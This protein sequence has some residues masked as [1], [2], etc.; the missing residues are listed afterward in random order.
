[1]N[2]KRLIGSLALLLSAAV[3]P[4]AA[5]AQDGA[6]KTLVVG[7]WGGDIERLLKQNAA[8]PLEADTGAKVEFLLG[9]SGDR[10]SKI[11][12]ERSNPTMDVAFVNIYEAPQ[13][14]KDGLVE[15]PDPDS[16]MFKDVWDG[17]NKGCYAMSLV[18]LGIAYNKEAFATPP[19][20]ADLWKP[21]YKGKIA[22]ATYPGSEGDG[23]L[24]V[25]ARLAGKDEH[26]ADAAFKKLAELGPPA[27]TYT[28]LDEVFAQM[29][30]GEV[31]AAPMISGYVLA[32]LKQWKNIGFSFPKSPGPVLVRDMVCIVKGAPNPDLAKRF[33][34]LALGVKNQTDYAEQLY[35]G[36]TNKTV[37]LSPEVSADVIDKPEEVDSLLQ[38]DWPYVIEQRAA[39]TERWN[40]EILGQ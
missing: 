5:S 33:V 38:L 34:A 22:Q 19:E 14:L 17:M 4:G 30:A 9:G 11:Y 6:G 13:L 36:P 3:L 31:V 29:D 32:G 40:K 16:A 24:G 2:A 28:S 23:I 27:L 39:W 37:K 25:A 7:T 18:G 10:V 1:M 20:W 12:A 26:D 8:G 21:E 35:F 15:A